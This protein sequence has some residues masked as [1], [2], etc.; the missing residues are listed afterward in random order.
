MPTIAE[1]IY[2]VQERIAAAARRARRDPTAITLVAVTK[3]HSP[4]VVAEAI[5]AGARHLGENRVQE[6]QPKIVDLDAQRPLLTWHLIGHLQRNKAKTVVGL[7]DMFHALDSLRL[8]EAL[9]RHLEEAQT[10]DTARQQRFPVLLQVNVSGEASKEGFN[11]PGGAANREQLPHFLTQVE[12]IVALPHLRVRGLMTIAPL[13]ANP[14]AARPVF[15]TLR[16]LRDTLAQHFPSTN[17]HHLS[18][19]MTDDFEVAIEEGAT[20]VRVGRAIFGARPRP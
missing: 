11:L 9:N 12:H 16:L 18:M 14:E 17:W 2:E 6:A 13:V 8:A 10:G 5:A 1:R 19:G 3:T 15:R 7:F 4:D 20:V